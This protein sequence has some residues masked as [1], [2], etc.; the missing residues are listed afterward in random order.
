MAFSKFM[1]YCGWPA[2]FGLAVA[3]ILVLATPSLRSSLVTLPSN[4]ASWFPNKPNSPP[5]N[6][7]LMGPIS[8]A[9]AVSKA[10]P[11]VVN[12]YSLKKVKQRRN[13]LYDDPIFRLLFNRSAPVQQERL[14]SA[15]GSGVIV[16]KRGYLVTNN[17][18]IDGADEIIVLLYDGR[19][20]IAT[21]VG[22]DQASDLAVLKIDLDN[23]ST[24]EPGDPEKIRIGDVVLAIGN[25]FGVG[26][27]VTQGIVSATGRYGLNPGSYE[28]FIQTDAAINQGNSGGAL[29]DVY[30]RLLGI[31]TAILDAKAGATGIGFATPAN[32]AIR[33]MQD[34]I[35][36]GYVVR[37]WLGIEA[38][39][40]S[41]RYAEANNLSA[42]NGIVIE[43]VTP[44]S[45]A[46]VAGLRP[47]DIITHINQHP[48]GN[49][50]QGM[51]TI[52]D[53]RPGDT[54]VIT[55][56]RAAE[57]MTIEV[58]V[59]TNPQSANTSQSSNS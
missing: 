8:Y 4:V 20:A 14:Q 16:D 11:A 6:T 29:V 38:Q 27:T 52:F 56:I 32:E 9:D 57:K 59:G 21:L 36:Y 54:V 26:Q 53:S 7:S 1:R 33:V 18:V 39:Q 34:I 40:L 48:V 30:G 5:S 12:I 45:P 15:L 25:P 24:I 44:Q 42:S 55:L 19:E 50:R 47:G 41:P 23:L 31:N 43:A 35:K 51:R 49:G 17:H 58:V 3:L 10:A 46:Q 37:G 13:P 2:L 22:T 28:N